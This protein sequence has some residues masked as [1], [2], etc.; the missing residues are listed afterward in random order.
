MSTSPII[1][2]L[3]N[4]CL[5]GAAESLVLL[6]M[7]NIC[8]TLGKLAVQCVYVHLH[9]VLTT[10]ILRLVQKHTALASL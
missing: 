7:D 5:S 3:S 1:V 8:S 6:K 9:I 10:K 4:H 2:L